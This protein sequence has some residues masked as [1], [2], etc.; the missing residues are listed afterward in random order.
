MTCI[1]ADLHIDDLRSPQVSLDVASSVHPGLLKSIP[2]ATA[3]LFRRQILSPSCQPRARGS[4]VGPCDA[5]VSDGHSLLFRGW[6]PSPPA[7]AGSSITPHALPASHPVSRPNPHRSRC[8]HKKHEPDGK[9]AP[10]ERKRA[11][12]DCVQP[13]SACLRPASTRVDRP[14]LRL[15]ACL[16]FYYSFSLSLPLLLFPSPLAKLAFED[17]QEQQA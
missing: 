5:N 9:A 10:A 14:R 12:D 16:Y 1:I 2:R 11:R 7:A 13:P 8:F 6:Q 4:T 3:S 15:F 17:S